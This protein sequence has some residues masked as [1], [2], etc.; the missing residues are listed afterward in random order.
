[1][2]SSRIGSCSGSAPQSILNFVASKRAPESWRHSLRRSAACFVRHVFSCV[3]G[4]DE[5]TSSECGV[6][7][8]SPCRS[9]TQSM[10]SANRRPHGSSNG[11]PRGDRI[12]ARA[13]RRAG[14]GAI[15]K[16]IFALSYGDASETLILLKIDALCPARN[17]W[18]EGQAQRS[19]GGCGVGSSFVERDRLPA[20]R[21]E[22]RC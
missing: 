19:F 1:M 16:V 22:L 10:R 17:C 9:R 2:R 15:R 13:R 5:A 6:D 4:V 8:E 18:V 7:Q 14:A 21:S 3:G 20:R 11:R 12:R